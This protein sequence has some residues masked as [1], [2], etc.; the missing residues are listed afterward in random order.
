MR[1]LLCLLAL[2]A[3][4][5]YGS[6][7]SRV[8]YS[9]S[10][11]LLTF[12]TEMAQKHGFNEEKLVEELGQAVYKQSIVD[13]ISR[14]AERR[15]QWNE[16]QDIFLNQR[17][18]REGKEFLRANAELLRE[19][20]EGYGVPS[21]IVTAVLGVETYYGRRMGSYRVMDAL[22]TLAFSYPPR[23]RFFRSELEQF[24]LLA[25]EEARSLADFHGSYAGAMGYGQFIPS[26]YRAYAVDQDGDGE[27]DIWE[28]KEDAAAS[29]ANYLFR[30]GWQPG[31]AIIGRARVPPPL[32]PEFGTE[33]KPHRTLRELLTAGVVS[34]E[35]FDPEVTVAPLMYHGKG[36]SE[37]WLAQ[38][39][40][41]VIT[42]YNRSRLY[43][44]AVYQLSQKLMEG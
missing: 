29:V 19:I 14:P 42:R 31:G 3:G 5:A 44:M 25:R 28:N 32:E 12:V 15:L 18:I 21:E 39:N 2:V 36:G 41:Y 7:E 40:F 13:A 34:E 27:R 43:A 30:H 22:A 33:I 38:H 4:V 23:S 35:A 20:E 10:E 9:G 1:L 8:N 37:Y 11:E 16:Y 6:Q 24:L 17:R 26:S